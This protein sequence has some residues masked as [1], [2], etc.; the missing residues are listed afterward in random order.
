MRLP[1]TT[2]FLVGVL[3]TSSLA[4]KDA[5]IEWHDTTRDVFIN[6]ELDRS[7]VVMACDSP[8][9]IALICSKLEQAV[10]LDLT[11]QKAALVS[12]NA[13]SFSTDHATATSDSRAVTQEIGKFTRIDG[14]VFSFAVDAKPVLIRPH[15]GLTGEMT[16]EKLWETVPVW[17]GLMENY[18]PNAETV[19]ALKATAE[20]ATVT[21]AFGTWCPDSKNYVPRL[22]KALRMAATA[23][24]HVKLIGVDNQFREP[25]N[26]VQPRQI[27]N[28]PTVIVERSSREIGRIVETPAGKSIEDDLVAILAGKPG[29][30]VGRWERGPLIARGSYSYRDS[31]G[32]E[33]ATESWDLYNTAEGG[34]LAHSR[35]TAGDL[36]T[37]VFERVDSSRRPSFAEITKQ[38]GAD[39]TRTR[40]N[41]EG[42]TMTVRM[43]GSVSGV[44]LQTVQIPERLFLSPPAA[45][46][47]GWS[48]TRDLAAKQITAYLTPVEFDK[49]IGVLAMVS[50]EING[51]EPTHVPAGEFQARH[52]KRLYGQEASDL[53]LLPELGI[54]VRGK[55][56]T[57]S[58]YVLTSL[59]ITS[60]KK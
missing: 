26:T 17:R 3:A 37:E 16:I 14:P 56:A 33:T 15:P 12:K 49:A 20:D 25:A 19:A 13:F 27:T 59:E 35:I 22:L 47:Q 44:I 21:V 2:L 57:G 39:R 55:S 11:E 34:Y 46:T 4:Q 52:L 36:D 40:I 29:A 58:E 7:A 43:R 30:H 60:L 6:N 54:P 18:Q 24:L 8:S 53:W 5:K 23:K 50:Q 42:Y 38:K 48:W 9:R 51:E 31:N 28:V 41:V 10:I 45:L 32:Q 1:F